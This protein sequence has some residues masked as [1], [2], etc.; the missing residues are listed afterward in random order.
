MKIFRYMYWRQVGVRLLYE[1]RTETKLTNFARPSPA[2]QNR[3]RQAGKPET[4]L[5]PM[6]VNK[7]LDELTEKS[8]RFPL[9]YTR[10][11]KSPCPLPLFT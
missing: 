4:R 11:E 6:C 7:A 3:P 5:L 8:K 9:P 1:F 2:N 10:H